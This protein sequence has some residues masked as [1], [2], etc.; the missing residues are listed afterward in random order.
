MSKYA[1]ISLLVFI[2]VVQ[3][4]AIRKQRYNPYTDPVDTEHVVPHEELSDN[5]MVSSIFDALLAVNDAS[6][7]S[8]ASCHYLNPTIAECV[9]IADRVFPGTDKQLKFNATLTVSLNDDHHSVL[10]EVDVNHSK[11]YSHVIEVDALDGE[12]T[13]VTVDSDLSVQLCSTFSYT[14]AD[15]KGACFGTYMMHQLS[16][17]SIGQITLMPATPLNSC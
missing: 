14:H 1:L 15:P 5:H 6:L 13:C 8:E 9:I 11:E 3:V 7:Y 16:F 4:F 17:G 10:V 2:S 12:P